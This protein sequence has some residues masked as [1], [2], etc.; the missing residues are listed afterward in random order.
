M[1]P[2]ASSAT[3]SGS[4]NCTSPQ[5]WLPHFVTK[6]PEFVT[7]WRRRLYGGARQPPPLPLPSTA[8]PTGDWNCPSPLPKL[9]HFVT[10]RHGTVGE[11]THAQ[12]SHPQTCPLG[13]VPPQLGTWEIKHVSSEGTHSQ[14]FPP[15]T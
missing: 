15:D 11:Q 14:E 10:K 8:M 7:F 2:I 1:L 12:K 6:D 3:A 13:H 9:P 4:M 5:P